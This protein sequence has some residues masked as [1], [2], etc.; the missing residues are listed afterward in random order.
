MS[1]TVWLLLIFIPVEAA[2]RQAGPFATEA[3]CRIAER[4]YNEANRRYNGPQSA[5]VRGMR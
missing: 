3:E 5:C 1:A 2:G 4:A